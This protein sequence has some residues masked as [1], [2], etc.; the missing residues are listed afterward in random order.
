MPV[1]GGPY[2]KKPL[3]ALR[4]PVKNCG[5]FTGR[6]TA[7]FSASFAAVRPAT[8]SHLTLGFSVTMAEPNALCI[9]R[10]S[11]SSPPLPP[12]PPPPPLGLARRA[13]SGE[14]TGLARLVASASMS[15]LSS[16]ARSR[17]SVNLA[18][19]V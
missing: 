2:S 17:Y 8:S 6:I 3:H 14:L 11:S 1:P 10:A 9:L 4:L 18:L 16:S 15:F 5:N 19:M 13:L 7:S 12:P